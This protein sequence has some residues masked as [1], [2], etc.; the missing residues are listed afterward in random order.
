MLGQKIKGSKV[1]VW[2]INTGWSGGPYGTGERI[3][4]TYTR[5]MIRAVL[6]GR[7]AEVDYIPHPVFG[8][9]MPVRC[10]GVPLELLNPKNTWA[11][12]KNYDIK[13]IE[14]AQLFIANFEKYKIEVSKETMAAAPAI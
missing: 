3:K 6:E 5:A 4:L 9:A 8:I 2:M 1:N 10:P 13:A 7:L 11:D 12:K 14:L